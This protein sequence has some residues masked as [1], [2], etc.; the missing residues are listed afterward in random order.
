MRALVRRGGKVGLESIAA[1]RLGRDDDVL[2]QVILAGICRTDVYVARGL[3][4][5]AE[6]RILGH[7][8]VGVVVQAG[9][10]SGFHPGER[11]TVIPTFACGACAGCRA[12]GDCHDP[13]FLGVQRDGAFAERMVV[14]AKNLL[15]APDRLSA[16]RAAYTEPVAA[17]LA[18]LDAPLPRDGRGLVLGD[19]RIATL[20][21]R[22]LAAEGFVNFIQAR[23]DAPAL[24][25]AAFDCVIETEATASTLAAMVG[26]LKPHGLG[27]LKSRPSAA[28][29]LDVTRAVK[30]NLRLHAVAYGSFERAI[31]LL[32][33]GALDVD[34][35]LGAAFPLEDFEAAFAQSEAAAAPK[36]FFTVAE[37]RAP[38]AH[39]VEWATA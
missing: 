21:M 3:L 37:A 26:L 7:E 27:V 13:L 33:G 11:V 10:I 4:A 2:I 17:A 31:A 8:L 32:D 22:I 19:N 14:P 29:P 15:R 16:E 6:P 9:A 30:K 34:D 38:A 35:L 25:G 24:D 20:I 5:V 28:V 23:A 36:L 18:V 39:R 1:P 12:Q